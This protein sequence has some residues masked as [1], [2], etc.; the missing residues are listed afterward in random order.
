MAEFVEEHDDGQ[1]EQ[2]GNDVADESMTQRIETMQ[3]K[4][5]HQVPLDKSQRP[6]PHRL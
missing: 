1:D 2:E 3:E 5:R 4:I 6:R